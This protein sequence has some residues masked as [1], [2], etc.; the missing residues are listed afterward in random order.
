MDTRE[1]VDLAQRLEADAKRGSQSM[2]E[3]VVAMAIQDDKD[4]QAVRRTIELAGKYCPT[5]TQITHGMVE[6]A[7]TAMIVEMFAPHELPVDEDLWEKYYH[8]ARAALVA[9]FTD[10]AE[11][12]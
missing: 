1:L 8:T 9:A 6:R 12:N 4:A 7:A 11:T 10:E 5:K 2:T 3:G